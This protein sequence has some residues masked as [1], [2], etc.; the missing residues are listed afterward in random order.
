M[1][2][3]WLC[4]NVRSVPPSDGWLGPRERAVLAGLR[5]PKRRSDW[6][7]GRWTAKQAL[8]ATGVVGAAV[9]PTRL[10]ICAG[11]GGAP[12]ALL[13]GQPLRD[14]AISL[15]HRDGV[16]VCAVAPTAAAL[17]CDLERIEPRPAVFARDWF[18][19]AEQ[20][21]VTAAPAAARAMVETFVWSAKESVA[22]ALGEGW[23]LDARDVAIEPVPLDPGGW[24]RFGAAAG[25]RTFA[26]WGRS[27]GV[28]ILAVAA[29]RL[30]VPPRA[31]APRRT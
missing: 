9:A 4:R 18:T 21:W 17:G 11:P 2:V 23:R 19:P 13:D 29:P 10:E 30:P 8:F 6:R 22:K 7:L 24:I 27:L 28:W 3:Q 12:V 31:L 20:T 25:G 5:L 1:D 16:A 15:S 26:G 14:L